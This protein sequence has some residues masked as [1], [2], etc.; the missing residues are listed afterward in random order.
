V[1]APNFFPLW[2]S[3]IASDFYAVSKDAAGYF[4]FMVLVKQQIA[5]L[6]DELASGLTALKAIDEFNYL[7]MVKTKKKSK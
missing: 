7:R 2:D 4:Q 6:P 5:N 3:T 1:L